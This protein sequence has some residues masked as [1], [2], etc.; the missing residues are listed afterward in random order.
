M[1]PSR[2]TKRRASPLKT[3]ERTIYFLRSFLLMLHPFFPF[4]YEPT[5]Q[6][7]VDQHIVQDD[8]TEED[9]KPKDNHPA[10]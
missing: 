1:M 10:F 2:T 5:L 4:R 3:Y 8:E 9:E 7:N 6:V